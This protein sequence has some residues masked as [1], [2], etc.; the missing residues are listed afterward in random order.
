MVQCIVLVLLFLGFFGFFFFF[1][2]VG[3]STAVEVRIA[4]FCNFFLGRPALPAH[5]HTERTPSTPP[6]PGHAGPN[7]A[8]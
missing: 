1:L 3:G 5:M 6:V 7:L 4:D 8:I 2:L